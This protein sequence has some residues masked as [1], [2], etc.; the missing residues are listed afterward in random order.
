M[1]KRTRINK[2]KL[3]EAIPGSNGVVTYIA[4]RLGCSEA[5][6][7]YLI[8]KKKKVKEA[9]NQELESA[10]D[11]VELK[12]FKL[13]G[14]GSEGLIKFYLAKKGKDRGYGEE[15]HKLDITTAGEPINVIKLIEVVKN[16]K[17]DES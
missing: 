15:N 17:K 8:K 5:G 12:M 13:I 9:Y 2:N 3:I 7:R 6:L 16:E 1:K 11:N 14:E 4:R 10:L